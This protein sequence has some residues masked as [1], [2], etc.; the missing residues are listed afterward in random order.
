[1]QAVRYELDVRR[2]QYLAALLNSLVASDGEV[3]IVRC[4]FG[5]F[6]G[7][8]VRGADTREDGHPASSRGVNGPEVAQRSKRAD[9]VVEELTIDVPVAPV[10]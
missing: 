5:R 8:R 1:M 10:D 2:K 7:E 6:I 9:S 4:T 3:R